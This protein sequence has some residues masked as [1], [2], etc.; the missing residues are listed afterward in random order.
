MRLA[1]FVVLIYL[2]SDFSLASMPGAFVFEAEDSQES[3]QRSRPHDVDMGR[4][5]LVRD[6]RDIVAVEHTARKRPVIDVKLSAAG[7]I[8]IRRG[9][10]PATEAPELAPPSEDSH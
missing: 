3:V 4:Q 9:A 10:D 5:A 2:G 8:L 6:L 1:I 7:P